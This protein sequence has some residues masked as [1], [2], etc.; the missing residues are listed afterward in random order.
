MDREALARAARRRQALEALEFERERESALVE[1]LEHTV[2]DAEG[3]RLDEAIFA[4]MEPEQ[5]EIVRGVLHGPSEDEED[6]E[7]LIEREIFGPDPDD[8]ESVEEEIARLE[9]EL[10]DCRTRQQAFERYLAGL[11]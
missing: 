4:G 9:Q 11:S 7:I 3:R 8:D 6:E 10:A 1:Q 5:V 2:A